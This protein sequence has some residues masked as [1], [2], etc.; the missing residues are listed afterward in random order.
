M[1]TLPKYAHISIHVESHEKY[2]NPHEGHKAFSRLL[3]DPS[4]PPMGLFWLRNKDEEKCLCDCQFS[5][6]DPKHE[7][8]LHFHTVVDHQDPKV[9]LK[10]ITKEKK[11][12]EDRIGK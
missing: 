10:A 12:L 5:E 3:S 2:V 4:L 6:L 1:T 7:I 9:L 8:G 11:L